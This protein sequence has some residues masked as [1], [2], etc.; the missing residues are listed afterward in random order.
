VASAH[1]VAASAAGWLAAAAGAWFVVGPFLAPIWRH[2]YIGTAV[3][4]TT[5]ISVEQIG[6]FYGLGAAILFL[7]GV[8]FGRFSLTGLNDPASPRHQPV[9]ARDPRTDQ[10]SD[11]PEETNLPLEPPTGQ[12]R[13]SWTRPRHRPVTH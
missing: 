3:G 11:V 5:H 1:R 9:A 8:A 10:S 4:D 12:P 13:H 6:M 2:D 7:A